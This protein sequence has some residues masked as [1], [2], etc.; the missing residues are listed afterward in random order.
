[1]INLDYVTPLE[2]IRARIEA[3]STGVRAFVGIL[4][5]EAGI[6]LV[7][8]GGAARHDYAGNV[9]VPLQFAMNAKGKGIQEATELLGAASSAIHRMTASGD[10]WQMTGVSI[11]RGP[12]QVA[13]DPQGWCLMTT[14]GTA[15]L[16]YWAAEDDAAPEA[17]ETEK[18]GKTGGRRV[19]APSGDEGPEGQEDD[20]A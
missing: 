11:Q 13:S 15:R 10:G 16:V 2:A 20:E 18:A 7:M 17:K 5:P 9:M 19:A 1:M 14:S 8:T 12:A 3:E 4:P 6:S